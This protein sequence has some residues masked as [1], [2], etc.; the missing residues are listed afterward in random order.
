MSRTAAPMFVLR[1]LWRY[2]LEPYSGPEAQALEYASRMGEDALWR[3][4]TGT[5]RSRRR[6][7][8]RLELERAR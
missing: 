2:S 7:S 6:V 4:W 8:R 3:Q 1:A 5:D